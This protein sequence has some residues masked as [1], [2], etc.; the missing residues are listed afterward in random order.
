MAKTPNIRQMKNAVDAQKKVARMAGGGSMKSMADSASSAWNEYKQN[1]PEIA[2]ALSFMPV[3]AQ[4]TAAAEFN[5][6]LNKKDPTAAGMA[7][8]QAIPAGGLLKAMNL[9]K[10]AK[11]IKNSAN[12]M[13]DVAKSAMANAPVSERMQSMATGLADKASKYK[14]EALANYGQAAA[15]TASDAGNVAEYLQGNVGGMANGGQVE[16]S[17]DAMKAALTLGNGYA[18]GG[19]VDVTSVGANEA[20]D[21]EVKTFIPQGGE[22]NMGG[23]DLD[24]VQQGTQLM[25]APEPQD[26]VPNQN[27]P[28][29][30]DQF[31]QPQMQ[32]QPN[33]L[34][35]NQPPQIAPHP[36]PPQP[37]SNILQMT[38]QG[39][40]MAALKPQGPALPQMAH[41]GKVK[42]TMSLDAMKYALTNTKKAK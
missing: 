15:A 32:P 37:A 31:G 13:I 40:A 33:M 10:E 12:G 1:N 17:M 14:N 22:M 18:E 25:K 28:Q 29:Q 4:L 39:Q 5:D 7:A 6:A 30:V 42:G 20:P 11:A 24:P 27:A 35:G 16:P 21:L 38:K 41:G 23:V 34:G 19:Q 36:M 9:V 2:L 26:G 8:I 3:A